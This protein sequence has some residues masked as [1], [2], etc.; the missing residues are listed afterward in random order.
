MSE[1]KRGK[2]PA[3][4]PRGKQEVPDKE[5]LVLKR[6]CWCVSLIIGVGGEQKRW[7]EEGDTYRRWACWTGGLGRTRKRERG[8]WR[9]VNS[10]TFFSQQLKGFVFSYVPFF[11]S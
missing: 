11:V 2:M 5:I 7:A 8:S 4:E 6:F 9:A 10:R 3:A 1:R